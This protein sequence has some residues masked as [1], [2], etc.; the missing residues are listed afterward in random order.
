MSSET[1]PEC[2]TD[3]KYTHHICGKFNGNDKFWEQDIPLGAQIPLFQFLDNSRTIIQVWGIWQ[4]SEHG[5]D[6]MPTNIFTK[7][8]KD[9]MKTL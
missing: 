2:Q 6:I 1:E 7:F 4:V 3:T 5:R 8:D 9:R